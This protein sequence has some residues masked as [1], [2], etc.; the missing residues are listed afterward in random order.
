MKKEAQEHAADDL[1]KAEL[2]KT[3]YEGEH[4][5]YQVEQQLKEHG[6]K[7]SAEQRSTVEASI[8]NVREVMKGD[9]ADAMKK[10]QEKLLTDAQTLGKAVYEEVAKQQAAQAAQAGPAGGAAEGGGA[11]DKQDDDVIDAEF[12]VKDSK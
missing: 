11:A 5:A 8:N 10:A 3:R 12:E 1:K 7:I 4:A 6:D 2:V 9:D